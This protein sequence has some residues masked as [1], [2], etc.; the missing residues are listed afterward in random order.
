MI[1]D[2]RDEFPLKVIGIVR[3]SQ[4]LANS[5]IYIYHHI[6]VFLS[7]NICFFCE[8]SSMVSVYALI[9]AVR[10]N[11]SSRPSVILNIFAKYLVKQERIFTFYY[12]WCHINTNYRHP[13]ER[14]FPTRKKLGII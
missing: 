14:M 7:T 5:S 3:V 6:H 1:Q 8:G 13:T 12:S 11:Q 2:I 9:K 10:P 4:K